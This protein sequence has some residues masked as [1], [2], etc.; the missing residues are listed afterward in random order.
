M[1]EP[2][3]VLKYSRPPRTAVSAVEDCPTV[4]ENRMALLERSVIT[5][6]DVEIHSQLFRVGE[7]LFETR[8][9]PQSIMTQTFAGAAKTTTTQDH[10]PVHDKTS[11]D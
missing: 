3:A 8:P 6:R 2:I 1:Q 5:M 11:S 4:E 9:C 7:R 10:L